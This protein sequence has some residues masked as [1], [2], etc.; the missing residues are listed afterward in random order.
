MMVRSLLALVGLVLAAG[1]SIAADDEK[2]LGIGPDSYLAGPEIVFDQT[3]KEDLFAAGEIVRGQADLA[4]SA[5]MAGRKLRMTGAVGGDAYMVGMDV[6]LD[7]PVTGDATLMGYNVTV[8]AV[9]GNL[10]ISG[11]DLVIGGPISGYALIA[12]E[13]VRLEGAIGGDAILTGREVTFADGARIDGKLTLYE[14]E[15]GA[16]QIPETWPYLLHIKMEYRSFRS[17]DHLPYSWL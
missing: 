3:G 4:G 16:L 17:S 9:G 15:P 5:H 6:V 1:P 13:E 2:V 11:G 14:R 7:G 10:R 8:G 12:G